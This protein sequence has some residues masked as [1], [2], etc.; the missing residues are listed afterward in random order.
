VTNVQYK[1][2]VIFTLNADSHRNKVIVSDSDRRS[3]GIWSW[4]YGLIQ[5]KTVVKTWHDWQYFNT[6]N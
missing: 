1:R 5:Y 4:S 2:F 6:E 3:T